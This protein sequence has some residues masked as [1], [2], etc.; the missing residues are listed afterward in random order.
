MEHSFRPHFF[1][2]SSTA[3]ETSRLA[4]FADLKMAK[5]GT[6]AEAIVAELKKILPARS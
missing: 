3:G 6:S 2:S 4:L 5:T 1:S